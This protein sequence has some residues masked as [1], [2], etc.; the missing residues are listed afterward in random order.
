[1]GEGAS[2]PPQRQQQIQRPLPASI[3]DVQGKLKFH[4]GHEMAQV[5]VSAVSPDKFIDRTA[6]PVMCN[7]DLCEH[8]QRGGV[9]LQGNEFQ[10]TPPTVPSLSWTYL[11]SYIEH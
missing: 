4:N 2:A 7:S 1:V 9:W 3:K 5:V 11:T 8:V 6:D 10:T